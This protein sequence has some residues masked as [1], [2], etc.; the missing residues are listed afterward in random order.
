MAR[1]A[2]HQVLSHPAM[3]PSRR[4]PHP[5]CLRLRLASQATSPPIRFQNEKHKQNIASAYPCSEFAGFLIKSCHINQLLDMSEYI[6]SAI[7]NRRI[8]AA[9]ARFGSQSH[10]DRHESL[11]FLDAAFPYRVFPKQLLLQNSKL[12]SGFHTIHRIFMLPH[13]TS[14]Y[15]A[16][17][18]TSQLIRAKRMRQVKPCVSQGFD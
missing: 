12:N 17:I 15:A 4:N 6:Y 9:Y 18:M 11:N 8:C 16:S 13:S 3:N 14:I 10:L 2:I 1:R 7:S 5:E